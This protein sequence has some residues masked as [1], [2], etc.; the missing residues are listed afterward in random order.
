MSTFETTLP[1]RSV[2]L[3]KNSICLSMGDTGVSTTKVFPETDSSSSSS[4]MNSIFDI[5]LLDE[6]NISTSE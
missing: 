6:M 2:T 4:E 5:D 1:S 3:I